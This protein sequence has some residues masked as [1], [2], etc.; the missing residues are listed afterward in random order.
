M[1]FESKF[2]VEVDGGVGCS[3][4]LTGVGRGT[5]LEYM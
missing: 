3:F 5:E 2:V 1:V 4:T